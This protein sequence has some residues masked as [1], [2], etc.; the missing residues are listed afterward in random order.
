PRSVIG[1]MATQENASLTSNRSTS[2]TCQPALS[3]TAFSAETGAV[4]HHS[5]ACEWVAWAT[6][7]AI[8]FSPRLAASPADISTVAAAPS[9]IL[10]A[11]AAVS[12]PSLPQAGRRLGIFA[13]STLPGSSSVSTPTS[14]LRVLTVTGTISALNAP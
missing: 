3:R 1:A 10:D 8:G 4:V 5:G 13:G 11:D 7:R 12:A 6:I 14:P 2:P 9:E